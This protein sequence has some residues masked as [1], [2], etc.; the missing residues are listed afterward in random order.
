MAEDSPLS[1]PLFYLLIWIDDPPLGDY[2]RL[3]S[4]QTVFEIEAILQEKNKPNT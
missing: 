4:A 2:H 3:Y 1:T